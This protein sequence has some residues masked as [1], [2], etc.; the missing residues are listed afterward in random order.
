MKT[1]KNEAANL[2]TKCWIVDLFNA[3]SPDTTLQRKNGEK[4][5]CNAIKLS[6]MQIFHD[7]SNQSGTR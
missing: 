2:D 7:F 3:D 5:S 6:T 1:T 4:W